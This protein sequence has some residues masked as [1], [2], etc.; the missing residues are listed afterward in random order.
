MKE[1]TTFG[2]IKSV[3]NGVITP[4]C[5][6]TAF[7]SLPAFI[8]QF[9]IGSTQIYNQD[10]INQTKI[11]LN[12]AVNINLIICIIAILVTI[13]F[14]LKKNINRF[15]YNVIVFSAQIV[16]IVL[17]LLIAKQLYKPYLDYLGHM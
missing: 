3:F 13:A 15:V 4:A 16:P 1:L 9:M 17:I 8:V 12:N 5:M 7:Y 10:Y 2:V 6:I 11:F 14:L